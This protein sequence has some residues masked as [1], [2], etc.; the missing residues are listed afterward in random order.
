MQD[1]VVADFFRV[2]GGKSI[3]TG[4]CARSH[5]P[6][7]AGGPQRQLAH[8]LKETGH[9]VAVCTG[10]PTTLNGVQLQ[11]G[12]IERV[13]RP[14]WNAFV[15][16]RDSREL[17][18]RALD[19]NLEPSGA[20]GDLDQARAAGAAAP[21]ANSNLAIVGGQLT[22]TDYKPTDVDEAWAKAFVM[23]SMPM[24]VM[25]NPYFRKA[26]EVT[27]KTPAWKPSSRHTMADT[28]VLTV[29]EDT[30]ERVGVEIAKELGK[31]GGCGMS[32]GAK[33]VQAPFVHFL[34]GLP[35]RVFFGRPRTAAALRR[36][37][38]GTPTNIS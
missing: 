8:L 10:L 33:A 26:L 38:S 5:E 4:T 18:R 15:A 7:F 24:T 32:D 11:Q 35:S 36:M 9:G 17:K 25:S 2:V 21:S 16:R 37:P 27:R 23:N 13:L 29:Y 28:H 14:H 19:H 3:C 6:G 1:V 22:L 34:L 31:Y 30:K 12:D 20:R